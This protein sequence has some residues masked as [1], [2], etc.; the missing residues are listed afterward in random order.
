VNNSIPCKSSI[1]NNN[2]NLPAAEFSGFF[3]QGVDVSCIHDIARN[4]DC[5]VG[6]DVID[7]FGD[8]FCFGYFYL[9]ALTSR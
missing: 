5:A 3:H 9:S 2:V 7:A 8:C 6:R 4:G 1:I